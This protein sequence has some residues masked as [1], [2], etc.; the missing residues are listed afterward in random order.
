M[1]QPN[2]FSSF[3]MGGFESACHVNKYRQRL[4]MIAATQHDRFVE[5]DYLRLRSV[6]I[7]SV[8]DTV[9]WHLI[10]RAG[11]QFDF[12]SL[13]PM[14][15]A[16]SR[17]KMQVVWDL[18]HYGWP[19]G[20]DIYS[21]AFV[22]RFARFCRAVARRIREEGDEVPL[23][24]PM[25]EISFF[26]W[27]AGEVG[28]FLPYGRHRGEELKR[29]LVRACIAGTEAVWEVDPRARIA[30]VEPVIHVVP[31]KERPELAAEAA[32]YSNSQFAAWDMLS[33]RL[34][35]ELGG[36]P[37]Y[38]DLV[39]VNFYHDNQWEQPGGRKIAWHIHPRD[40]RWVP[41]S[42]LFRDVYERYQRPIFVA[43][44]SH[45]GSGRAEWI[46]EM[47][48]ELVLAIEAGVPVEAVCLY[49]VIDRFEWN[50]PSHWHNSGL[51]DFTL[52]TQGNFV[53]VL[54]TEYAREFWRS[55]L[56]LS[57]LGYGA[58]PTWQTDHDL[59]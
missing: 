34:H 26:C 37:R 22:E 50:N 16:A 53:R 21:A 42:R 56:K 10:E 5:E 46:R 3:W 6:G 33:G 48:D 58:P 36:H 20:L 19:D 51:W 59:T 28:W 35:P 8:R 14:L 23:Y 31:P 29:Q 7:T 54:N 40:S 30:T 12:S 55:Q 15:A 32:A 27:A 57:Q 47:S 52:D 13:D 25:N 1:H 2:V 17:Q 18:C 24:T 41:F 45:V 49:P 43:E 44:T 4:D 39:G 38:L 9:R 11:G